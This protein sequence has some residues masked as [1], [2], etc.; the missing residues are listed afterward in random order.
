MLLLQACVAV[1]AAPLAS[2][3]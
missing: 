1:F 2:L 3:T